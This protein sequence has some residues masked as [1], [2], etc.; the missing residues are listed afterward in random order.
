MV[1]VLAGVF[2][3][4]G[5]AKPHLGGT[6]LLPRKGA[7]QTYKRGPLRG[8]P[9]GRGLCP[10]PRASKQ[11]RKIEPA[12]SPAKR[13]REDCYSRLALRLA[14]SKQERERERDVVPDN[15]RP[16]NR[17]GPKLSGLLTRMES[18]VLQLVGILSCHVVLVLLLGGT[19]PES[20]KQFWRQN[21]RRPGETRL[22]GGFEEV[23][24]QR[25][26]VS[27]K[28]LLPLRKRGRQKGRA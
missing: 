19:G 16:W 15:L 11:A 18:P 25:G 6:D 23:F 10:K 5:V 12:N 8:W 26:V 17:R 7:A 3:G 28:K 20:R 13:K 27:E 1:M 2:W 21:R 14:A 4:E 9:T 24:Q 22:G